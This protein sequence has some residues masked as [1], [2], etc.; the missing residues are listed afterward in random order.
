MKTFLHFVMRS[1]LLFALLPFA[2]SAAGLKE[3]MIALDRAYIPA[4]SITNR[5][6]Q[7]ADTK[8]AMNLMNAQWAIFKQ[9]YAAT[10]GVDK[11]WQPDMAKI[12][13][14]VVAANRIV[15]SGKDF[16]KAHEELEGVRLTFLEMRQ[17]AKMPYY[18]DDLTRFHDPMEEM[19][20]VAKGKS[21]EQL[22]DTDIAKIRSEFPQ[23][24]RLWAVV[25]KA[26]VDSAF[27]LTEG[28]K[29]AQAKLMAAETSLLDALKQALSAN[30]RDGIAKN[31]QALRQPFSQLYV[32]FGDFSPFPK[33]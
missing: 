32:S 9:K 30:D 31:A 28:Q 21:G 5:T 1:L 2:A 13:G 25:Q 23:A 33:K 7:S 22:S 20:L 3:D 16:V 8:L 6:P 11:Q 27:Q 14:Y 10:Q 4:L 17:R 19:Y 15:D 26:T 12:D 18:L 24:E 29:G